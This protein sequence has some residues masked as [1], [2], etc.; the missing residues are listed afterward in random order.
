MDVELYTPSGSQ[1]Y[2]GNARYDIEHPTAAGETPAEIVD[3]A[4]A[5]AT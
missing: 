4:A 2:T 1:A 3:L 5:G